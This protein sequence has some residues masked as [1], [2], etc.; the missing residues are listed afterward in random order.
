MMVVYIINTSPSV[1]LDGDVLERVWACKEVSNRHLRV[2][3][4]LVYVHVAKDQRG[5][6][7]KTRPCIFLG[8]GEFEFG[9]GT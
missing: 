9:Y 6:L 8:Y 4:C 5:K 3:G 2:L 1:P 7:D